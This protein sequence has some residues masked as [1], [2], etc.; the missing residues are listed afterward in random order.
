VKV[1]P[2][3]KEAIARYAEQHVRKAVLISARRARYRKGFRTVFVPISKE[4]NENAEDENMVNAAL[5]AG[6]YPKI[7]VVEGGN[8]LKTLSNNQVIS[9]VSAK[10]ELHVVGYS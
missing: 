4:L 8:G 10:N 9:V 5:V 2:G 7:L 1:S 3:E 6:L